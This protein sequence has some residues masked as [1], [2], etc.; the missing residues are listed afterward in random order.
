MIFWKMKIC[1]TVKNSVDIKIFGDLIVIHFLQLV[2]VA[3][4]AMTVFLRTR[5]QAGLPDG[6]YYLG[7]LFFS[8][9]FIMFNGFAEMSLTIFRLPVF[10]KQRDLLFYPAWAYTL[11]TYFLRIPQSIV[12]SGLWVSLT[13]YVIGF[14]PQP[15]RF[16][17]QYLLLFLMHQMSS[18]LFRF[19]GGLCRS[20]IMANTGGSFMLL[21]I[22]MLGGFI[23]PR[24]KIPAWWIWG[25]WSSPL[26]YGLTASA[27][28]E[29]LAP[30]WNIK[31]NETTTAGILTLQRRG[32]HTESYLYW[33]SIASLIGFIVL[34]NVLFTVSMSYLGPIGKPQVTMSEEEVAEKETCDGEGEVFLVKSSK[35]HSKRNTLPLSLSSSRNSTYE[36]IEMQ[37]VLSTAQSKSYRSGRIGNHRVQHGMSLPFQPLS[38]SFEDVKYFVDMPVEMMSQGVTDTRLQLLRGVTGSFRPG[39]LTALMGVSGAGKTTLMDVLAGRKTGGYIEGDVHISGYRKKQ[40]TF[41]R[42]SGYCEQTDIHS[43]QVTVHESLIYSAQLRL[44]PEIDHGTKMQFV[45]EVMELVELA[46]LNNALV[47]LP[48]V[49][50]LSTEQRKRLTIAVELVANPSIIFMDEPTSGLDARAAAIVMRAVRNTVDTGRTVVCTIHQPSIDIFEAFDELLLMKRGGQVIYAGPLGVHSQKIIDYFEAIPGVSKIKDKYNP[51]TWM[52]EV[53]SMAVEKQLGIDFAELY[54][55]SSLAQRNK[56]IVKELSIPAAGSRDLHFPT[57]YC[58]NLWGQFKALLWKKHLTYWRS[59]D[60]NLV[61]F[62]FTFISALMFGTIFWQLGTKVEREADL[63]TVM[64]AMYGATLFLGINNCSTVQ[65]IVSV[66]RTVFYRERAAGMYSALPYAFA[67]VVIELPYVFFQ[68][69]MYGFIVY[70]MIGFEWMLRKCLWFLFTMFCTFLYFTYYGMMAVSITPN[71]QVAAIVASAFYSVFNLFAG[72]LMPRPKLPEWWSWYYWV[73]PTAWTVNGLITSQYSD[74]KRSIQ[75]NLPAGG[76]GKQEITEYLNRT[77]GFHRDFLGEVA[78]VL[79]VF[80]IFFALVFTVCVRTLNFQRR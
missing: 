79:I 12:E 13:Y 63:L 19:I 73:C 33:T 61:R 52:L 59:P 65:P 34:F 64:G 9:N 50:G 43:P 32:L 71:H 26:Q 70:S 69:I 48:G 49:S 68:T 54:K 45:K 72:F 17:R 55:K 62:T 37:H 74:A 4:I 27:V 15:S 41:A 16:F 8:L 42:I 77:F 46:N 60:Y 35:W 67:Q 10:F 39:V 24:A 66:E 1:N 18:S 57:Q 23:I 51:A 78:T 47:G 30:R 5:L 58:Q 75:V 14:A 31:V 6:A 53:S 3:F 25:Y 76:Q 36:P 38:I 22:F 40:E 11:P 56:E 44:S 20:M 21:V 29:F 28:N 80:P 7:A 2:I